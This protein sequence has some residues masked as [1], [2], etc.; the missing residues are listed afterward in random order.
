M[1]LK[2]FTLIELLVVIAIIALL[3]AII[4]PALQVAKEQASAAVCLSNNRQLAVIWMLYADDND[5]LLVDADTGWST[6]GYTNVTIPSGVIS[7]HNF[8]ADPQDPQGNRRNTSLE[9]KIRGYKK[10]ALWPYKEDYKVYNCPHDRRYREEPRDPMAEIALDINTVGGYRSYSMGAPL[11]QATLGYYETGENLVVIQK[12]GDFYNP[13]SKVVWI[14]EADGAGW[15]LRAWDMF[16]NAYR[17]Y[18]SFAIWHNGSSTFSYADGHADRHKWLEK[19]TIEQAEN[20]GE[21]VNLLPTDRDYNWFKKVY[22]P[23]R[24]PEE[25]K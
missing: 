5:G 23:G 22:I 1:R 9:D 13:G 19:T 20:Q 4:M 15:N 10:G 16:L 6:T 21:R 18:D 12:V 24:I 14:E 3:L 11:S 2:G 8:V 17:W 25:L 7:V